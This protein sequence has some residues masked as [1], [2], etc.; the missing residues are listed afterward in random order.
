MPFEERK[1]EDK[2]S[3]VS[4]FLPIAKYV[5]DRKKWI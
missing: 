3:V 5:L 1:R 2:G 4:H